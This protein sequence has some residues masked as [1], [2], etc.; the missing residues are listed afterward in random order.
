M[1]SLL[2]AHSLKLQVLASCNSA[3][4]ESTC[5]GEGADYSF[6][7]AL[8]GCQDS[9]GLP[10]VN[11][12]VLART[13]SASF[14]VLGWSSSGVNWYMKIESR[15]FWIGGVVVGELYYLW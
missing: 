2:W 4:R 11:P 14:S 5:S 10:R 9:G 1:V 6:C 7:A 3:V 12:N 15:N 8:D 13:Y